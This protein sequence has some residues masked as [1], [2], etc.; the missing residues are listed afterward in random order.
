MAK[1]TNAST[2]KVT[3]KTTKKKTTIAPAVEAVEPVEVTTTALAKADGEVISNGVITMSESDLAKAVGFDYKK[4]IALLTPSQK[5]EYL[6]KASSIVNGDMTTVQMY[7]S[8]LTKTI[9]HNGDELLESVKSNNSNTEANALITNLLVELNMVDASDLNNTKLKQVLRKIPV[10]RNLV[11]SVDKVMIKYSSI[12]K[13]VD[14]IAARI[15]TH[16]ITAER[17]NNILEIVF[18]N[19]QE[20]IKEIRELIIAAKLKDQEL[21][22]HIEYMKEHPDEYAPIDIADAQSFENAL[23]KRI[24]NMQISEFTFSQDLFRIRA[25]QN[26]NISLSDNAEAI[27]TTVIP[28]WK[29]QLAMAVIAHNQRETIEIQKKM[30]KTTKELYIKN[31]ELMKQNTIDVARANEETIVDL[32]T[33]QKTTKDLIDTITEVKKIQ[34]EG[35]K[36]R[37]TIEQN[38]VNYSKQLSDKI[39]AINAEG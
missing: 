34:T 14:D 20:Y 10:L 15:R 28:M 12:K 7:G 38:L 3:T 39:N 25:L 16:K 21:L 33:L 2:S 22:D 27:V 9:E 18:N 26:N 30:S 4:Q 32:E 8:D 24:A 23:S 5:R 13:N 31:S 19:N 11:M 37:E 35:A 29:N 36:M 1:T 6:A 17:D